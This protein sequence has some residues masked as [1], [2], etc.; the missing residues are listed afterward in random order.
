MQKVAMN[1]SPNFAIV[2]ILSQLIQIKT[3]FFDNVNSHLRLLVK[4]LFFNNQRTTELPPFGPFVFIAIL[5]C[6][7]I[8][9]DSTK[10]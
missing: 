4:S 1:K 10:C 2:V 6:Q 8:S 3:R 9:E 7:S 5:G